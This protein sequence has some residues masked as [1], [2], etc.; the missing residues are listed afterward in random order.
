MNHIKTNCGAWT[1]ANQ[2]VKKTQK[3]TVSLVIQPLIKRDITVSCVF[4][5]C[6]NFKAESVGD[7]APET[8]GG[9]KKEHKVDFWVISTLEPR[10]IKL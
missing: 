5:S 9:T 3:I 2:G 10:V 1:T 6:S 8:A 7:F 4:A